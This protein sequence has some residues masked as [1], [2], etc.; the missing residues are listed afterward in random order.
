MSSTQEVGEIFGEG[1]GPAHA[2]L[3]SPTVLIASVGLWGM[4]VFFY[5][6]FGINYIKVLK[7]DLIQIEEMENP[8]KKAVEMVDLS[9]HSDEDNDSPLED[10]S[11]ND[12]SVYSATEELIQGAPPQSSSGIIKSSMDRSGAITWERLVSLSVVL[13]FLLHFTYVA[14]IDVLKG[15]MIGAVFAFYG[16]VALFIIAPFRCNRWLRRATALVLGRCWE[17]INPR[18]HCIY[19][20]GNTPPRIIPFVDVFFAD[21]M[22][23]LSKVF[24]D[25]G[26]L[27]HMAFHYPEPVPQEIQNILIPSACA[28]VPYFIRARQ[29]LV[30]YSVERIQNSKGRFNHLWNALKYS[31]SIFPL[32]LSAY[33]KTVSDE[34]EKD[35]EKYLIL[36]LIINSGFSLY[37]D[38]VMDWGMM[39]ANP[40]GMSL[41]G[42]KPMDLLHKGRPITWIQTILRPRLR[43]GLAMSAL[44]LVSDSLLRFSWCLR[45]VQAGLFASSDAFVLCTQFLEVF[46]R[47]LWNLLR[48][49]WENLKH[50]Q[51]P[52]PI[53]GGKSPTADALNSD[54]MSLP[55]EEMTGLF[56]GPK[57]SRSH[58]Q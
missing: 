48:V 9:D 5:R 30:M 22:C 26:M 4:N 12:E 29:C 39:Q 42:T 43:F 10:H 46:R 40:I 31:S 14:W 50:M 33:Q 41:C 2:M 1:R 57:L 11:S 47:A 15:G 8:G 51:K 16:V 55:S 25:W 36:L 44:I 58:S 28:A 21:A 19:N 24:F 56:P 23:S 27:L 38:I 34:L 45:F 17:L 37:W 49:D 52:L 7:R 18:C 13:L 35:L 20:D 6:L 3:R 32:C 53:G 54:T